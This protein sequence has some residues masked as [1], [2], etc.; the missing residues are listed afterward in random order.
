M[1]ELRAVYKDKTGAT[2]SCPVVLNKNQWMMVTSDG[3][4]PI[5]FYF[6]D[7]IAGRLTFD[8]Y[9]EEEDSRLHIEPRQPGQSS[10]RQL[11][12]A[13]AVRVNAERK[14]RE[15]AR[16]EVQNDAA[17]AVDPNARDLNNQLALAKKPRG[18]GVGLVITPAMTTA[19]S[20]AAL[21]TRRFK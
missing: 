17:Q 13:N 11:Q 21:R 8:C 3:P 1:A 15:V 4:Q 12:E 16:A 19:E 18:N 10:F 7:D 9:R 20:E 2:Y 5:T 14:Q 6:E